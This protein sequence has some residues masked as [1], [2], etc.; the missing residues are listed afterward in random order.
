MLHRLIDT[1][2]HINLAPANSGF[3]AYLA[4]VQDASRSDV[5]SIDEARKDYRNC[6]WRN[7]L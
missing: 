7:G 4:S 1:I 3:G 5:P 2:R 6:I